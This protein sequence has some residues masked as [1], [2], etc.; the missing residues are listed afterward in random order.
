MPKRR[1]ETPEHKRERAEKMYA[2]GMPPYKIAET[3]K[4]SPQTINNWLNRY[5]WREKYKEFHEKGLQ[6]LMDKAI[7]KSNETV[8]GLGKIQ[9]AAIKPILDGTL[10][11]Q[12]FG[13]A[14]K[15]FIE[16]AKLEKELREAAININFLNEV[17]RIL[18]EEVTD[19]NIQSRIKIRVMEL[20]RKNNNKVLQLTGGA[21]QIID[22]EVTD[23]TDRESE[24]SNS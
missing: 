2:A 20:A 17:A 6:V 10:Q 23:V 12:Y 11:P 19:P 13:E 4:V 16:S 14:T 8:D 9:D 1:E 22:G 21:D 3:V 7:V 5:G 15:A 24:I 18:L